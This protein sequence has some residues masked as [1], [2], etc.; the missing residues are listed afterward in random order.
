MKNLILSVLLMMSSKVFAAENVRCVSEDKK[1]VY[2]IKVTDQQITTKI[3][4]DEK[5]IEKW[6]VEGGSILSH[7]ATQY[8]GGNEQ[9]LRTLGLDLDVNGIVSVKNLPAKTA[10]EMR[11]KFGWQSLYFDSWSEISDEI[12]NCISN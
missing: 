8:L 7:Y 12:Y 3:E 6:N 10:F 5:S 2:L 9:S 4:N 1:K 11:I